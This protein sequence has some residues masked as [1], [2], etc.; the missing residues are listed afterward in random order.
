MK[1]FF[2]FCCFF[3]YL[4]SRAFSETS[5]QLL[6][7][8]LKQRLAAASSSQAET[9]AKVKQTL[10][11]RSCPGPYK[12]AT[13]GS[14]A[15]YANHCTCSA[16]GDIC[17]DGSNTKYCNCGEGLV[18]DSNSNE[19][20]PSVNLSLGKLTCIGT[21]NSDSVSLTASQSSINFVP[22][23][24]GK[25]FMSC[26]L[27]M[28]VSGPSGYQFELEEVEMVGNGATN[29]TV[30]VKGSSEEKVYGGKGAMNNFLPSL[31]STVTS[32]CFPDVAPLSVYFS[33]S[34]SVNA[35]NFK[36]NWST[37]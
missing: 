27:P 1:S 34:N 4:C 25:D 15:N 21:Q 13:Y 6:Q 10:E 22:A 16:V 11:K 35:I 8:S 3:I 7:Q 33:T 17:Q 14:L 26:Y 18:C 2:L 12:A 36:L 19:C 20:A 9:N 29:V 37:C 24:Q 5:E 23:L 28:I 30:G 32:S 31:T